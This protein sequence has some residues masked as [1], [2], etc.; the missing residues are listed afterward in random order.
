MVQEMAMNKGLFGFGAICLIAVGGLDYANQSKHAGQGLGQMTP[1]AYFATITGRVGV[2]SP[3]ATEIDPAAP[4]PSPVAETST[5][6]AAP[7]VEK[8]P[9]PAVRS[10][11]QGCQTRAG[12][13]FCSSGG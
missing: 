5:P 10:M 3:A 4:P 9:L 8:Q 12:T 1:A 2:N 6:E 7:A 11:T 13:K